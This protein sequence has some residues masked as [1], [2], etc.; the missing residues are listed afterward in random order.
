MLGME[1]TFYAV[2]A[3][4][5]RNIL[6]QVSLD[7]KYCTCILRADSPAL[8]LEEQD[9]HMLGCCLTGLPLQVYSAPQT[10]QALAGYIG[11]NSTLLQGE[12]LYSGKPRKKIKKPSNAA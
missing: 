4:D 9:G 7:N 5:Q 12:I 11:K 1:F 10:H 2:L 6:C 3:L 8:H